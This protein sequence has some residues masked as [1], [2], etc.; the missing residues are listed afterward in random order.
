MLVSTCDFFAGYFL[1][2]LDLFT[3]DLNFFADTPRSLQY[4]ENQLLVV[5]RAGEA[6][7]NGEYR[8]AGIMNGKGYFEKPL[9]DGMT[10]RGRHVI[11]CCKLLRQD[12]MRWFLS[13]VADRSLP[14]GRSD[15]NLYY[16]SAFPDSPC[17]PHAQ[18]D[19]MT[20]AFLTDTRIRV[21]VTKIDA[22][23]GNRDDAVK[24]DGTIVPIECSPDA[25][26]GSWADI[27]LSVHAKSAAV[28]SQAIT[29]L[30]SEEERVAEDVTLTL[31]EV[32][33]LGGAQHGA[34]LA[35]AAELLETISSDL[36]LDMSTTLA[37][38]KLVLVFLRELQR[39]QSEARTANDG[40]TERPAPCEVQEEDSYG[41]SCGN[42]L[43]CVFHL[44]PQGEV[45]A[46]MTPLLL[47]IEPLHVALNKGFCDFLLFCFCELLQECHKMAV[48]TH[49]AP[50]NFNEV[51]RHDISVGDHEASTNESKTVEAV[52]V[53]EQ[54]AQNYHKLF[55]YL[56]PSVDSRDIPSLEWFESLAAKSTRA[57]E[58]GPVLAVEACMVVYASLRKMSDRD[59]QAEKGGARARPQG[60]TNVTNAI[61]RCELVVMNVFPFLPEEEAEDLIDDLLRA[62][63]ALGVP[64]DKRSV[65]FVMLCERLDDCQSRV[66]S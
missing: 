62:T 51:S 18:W 16:S 9:E 15:V 44:V 14:G 66:R 8:F 49:S 54:F 12:N 11:Y 33:S 1:M 40:L 61:R 42:I 5:S 37:A 6:E 58:V 19:C 43:G 41:V 53:D 36:E 25:L 38:S 59:L 50:D 17:L 52:A 30:L 45:L 13:L 32:F 29:P 21:D 7:A 55:L 26:R 65:P 57:C 34:V 4:L 28:V 46:L 24:R 35:Q 63:T 48:S 10:G 20:D 60:P 22:F 47:S 23:D 39:L 64:A 31:R 2:L 3:V 56:F 27:S